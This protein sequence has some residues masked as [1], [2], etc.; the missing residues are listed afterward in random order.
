MIILNAYHEFQYPLIMLRRIHGSMK[1]GARLG[2]I[3]RDTDELRREARE[4]YAKTGQIKRRVTESR[5][6]TPYTDDHQLA[7]DVVERETAQI[8]FRKV[9]H[10]ELR[11]YHYLLIV[12]KIP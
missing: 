3:E 9:R 5:A 6:E 11:H 10:I 2:I 4:A 7:L 1:P 12:E 8:G